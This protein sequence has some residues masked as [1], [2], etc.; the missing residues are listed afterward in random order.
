MNRLDPLAV[1]L[2]GVHL[3]EASAGTG[4]T[5]A[6]TTLVVRAVL[7]QGLV[8]RNFLVGERFSLADI[9]LYAYTHVA[10]EGGFP[11]EPYPN[12]RAWFGRVASQPG[13]APITEP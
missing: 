7:E 10:E 1:D 12:I 3:V 6:I 4:K 13:H 11:L 9:G 8:G 5:H 2:R